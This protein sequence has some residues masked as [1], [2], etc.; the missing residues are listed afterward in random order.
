MRTTIPSHAQELAFYRTKGQDD[1]RSG[2]SYDPPFPLQVSV[3]HLTGK[4]IELN[5]AYRV[6]WDK[7]E[8]DG[9]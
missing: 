3:M 8:E 5:E 7:A 4:Q 9:R 2:H 1:Q 6:G